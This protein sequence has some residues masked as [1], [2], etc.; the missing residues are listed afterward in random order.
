[1]AKNIVHLL[2]ATMQAKAKTVS[3]RKRRL[4]GVGA[5]SGNDALKLMAVEKNNMAKGSSRLSKQ[6]ASD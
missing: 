4:A 3:V 2:T 1:M 6:T 5:F